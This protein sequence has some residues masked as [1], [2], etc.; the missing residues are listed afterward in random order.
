MRTVIQRVSR[1]QVTVGGEVIGR[2]GRGLVVL[3]GFTAGD[4]SDEVN[5]MARKIAGLRIFADAEGKFN[6]SALDI[7]GELLLV[8]QF[9]LMADT[10]KGR[11]PG[12]ESAM[13]PAEAEKLFNYFV[14]Q[15]KKT[16]LKVATGRFQQYMQV[17]IHNDGPVTIFIDTKDKFGNL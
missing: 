14:E 10:K 16:G 1:A 2:I 8:S 11:R 12:F 7:G 6:L 3:V 13:P 15:A 4:G 9:T 17:E 5:W